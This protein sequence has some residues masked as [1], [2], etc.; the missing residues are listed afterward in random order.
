[1]RIVGHGRRVVAHA[2]Q[3][4]SGSGGSRTG[5]EDWD[6]PKN[7]LGRLRGHGLGRADGVAC[8]VQAKRSA[9]GGITD[10]HRRRPSATAVARVGGARLGHEM[11]DCPFHPVKVLLRWGVFGDERSPDNAEVGGSI[12]PSPT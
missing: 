3:P 6:R 8:P 1:M 4:L 2:R 10:G 7:T 12:P 5:T 11:A 9:R